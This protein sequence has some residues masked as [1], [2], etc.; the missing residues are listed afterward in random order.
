MTAAAKPSTLRDRTLGDFVLGDILNEGGF[1]TVYRAQQCSLDRPAVV[2]VIRRSRTTQPES[3]ERFAREARL[4]SHFDH[5]YAAHIYAFGIEPDCLVWIAMELVK[6][7]PLNELLRRSGPL[8]LERFTP[9]FERLCEVIQSAHDQS[10]VH[11]DIKPSNVMVIARAGRLIPKLLDFGIARLIAEPVAGLAAPT[12]PP[13]DL[14]SIA[15]SGELPDGASDL[16]ATLEVP[17]RLTREGQVL[18]SPLYMAPEQWLDATSAGPAADQY[19]LA[20]VAFE[21]LTASPAFNGPTIEALAHQ[22]L[23]VPLRRLPPGFP[24]ALDGVLA[25]ATDKIAA[26]R[27]ATLT[28]FARSFRAAAGIGASEIDEPVAMLPIELRTAWIHDAPRPIAESIAALSFARTW[29]RADERVAAV[30]SLLAR[31][32]G[33]LAIVCRTR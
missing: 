28:E 5:P 20:L 11:R 18:G 26:R 1:G 10:I 14:Q 13:G 27:F 30:A 2:K 15:E 4:A 23:H 21:A 7:T 9:L 29:M 33:M 12:A 24:A 17:V 6:G 25:R 32:I 19:A 8:P 22:H 31:W 16:S 3:V